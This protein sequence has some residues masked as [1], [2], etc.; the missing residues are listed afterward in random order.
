M[1]ALQIH[2]NG[3]R[4]CTAG[5]G[6]AGVLTAIVRSD[7]RAVQVST[8]TPSSRANEQLG[9]DVGGLNSSTWEHIRWKTPQL[10]SGDEIL[11]R[12]IDAEVVDKP[13]R[14][15]RADP[16]EVINAEKKY[17]ERTAKKLG[18]KVVK[19]RPRRTSNS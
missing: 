5:I 11:I 7:I 17:V 18:W 6:D 12:I 13:S 1:R 9:L 2:L 14:R 15:E 3:K 16:A 10:R 4:L 19:P 8:R